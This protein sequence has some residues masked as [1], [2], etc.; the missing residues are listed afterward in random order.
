MIVSR[1][2][3][4]ATAGSVAW[5]NVTGKPSS[6]GGVT[7]I[8]QLTGS[9]FA[10]GQVPRWNGSRFVPYTIPAS[11]GGSSSLPS[12]FTLTWDVPVLLPLQTATQTFNV[13]N[14]YPQNPIAIAW[15]CD[16]GFMWFKGLVTDI[17]VITLSALNMDA[18]P[19]T[20]GEITI[21]VQKFN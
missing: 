3:W 2:N 14:I 20:F 18:V 12:Q 7:D 5:E 8:G 21:T 1:A 16:P 9:G 13:A 15:N 11:S 19:V 6:F 4:A 17:Q 10:I